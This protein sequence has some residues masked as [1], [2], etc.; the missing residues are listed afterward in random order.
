MFANAKRGEVKDQHSELDG[1][2]ITKLLGQEW[3]KLS[4]AE[5]AEWK[6]KAAAGESGGGEEEEFGEDEP[7]GEAG[8]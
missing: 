4:H 3:K 2:G 6:A 5:K 8:E 1:T 7:G